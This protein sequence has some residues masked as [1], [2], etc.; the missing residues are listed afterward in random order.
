VP[1][2]KLLV[3]LVLAAFGVGLGLA[4]AAA[5]GLVDSRATPPR[6]APPDTSVVRRA[7]IIP[8]DDLPDAAIAVFDSLRP[9]I[10]LNSQLLAQ[11]GPDLSAFLRAHEEGHI[12]YH[13][14]SERRFGL[15]RVE[16]PLPVLHRYEFAADCYAARALR[17]DRPA[18]VRAALRFFRERRALVTD[19]EHPAMGA[20]AERLIDCLTEPARPR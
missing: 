4:F 20:R 5:G 3:S 17:R 11:I 12:A 9:R 15:L 7:V 13:H 10:Y 8:R 1:A 2:H 19:A 14:V 18:A 16:T 6:T